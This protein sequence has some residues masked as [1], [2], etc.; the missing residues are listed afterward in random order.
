MTFE[1]SGVLIITSCLYSYFCC[2]WQQVAVLE[3]YFDFG[4]QCLKLNY[5]DPWP[6]FLNYVAIS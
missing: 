5:N 6:H 2:A 3:L 1:G 4:C